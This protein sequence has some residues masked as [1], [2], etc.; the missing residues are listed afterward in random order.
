MKVYIVKGCPQN[1]NYDSSDNSWIA[2]IFT[3]KSKAESYI[4]DLETQLIWSKSNRPKGK[5]SKE[6]KLIIDNFKILK[7]IGTANYIYLEK[8]LDI[9]YHIE[10]SELE[11]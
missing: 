8:D 1:F 5:N 10:E 4:K 7:D 6:W 2:K 11:E 9:E 3:H